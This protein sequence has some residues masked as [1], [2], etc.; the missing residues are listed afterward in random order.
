MEIS[1][2]KFLPLGFNIPLVTG[3]FFIMDV[4]CDCATL[5]A[6]I[7]ES[8]PNWNSDAFSYLIFLTVL[9]DGNLVALNESHKFVSLLSLHMVCVFPFPWRETAGFSAFRHAKAK[10]G[11]DNCKIVLFS[12]T[13]STERQKCADNAKYCILLW[14][15]LQLCFAFFFTDQNTAEFVR[16][17]STLVL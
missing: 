12:R 6:F 11:C 4:S 9:R 8:Q 16:F 7:D 17:S 5:G 14:L 2:H 13:C 15:V 3:S 1:Y 10:N